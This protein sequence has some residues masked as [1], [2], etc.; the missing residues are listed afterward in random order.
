MEIRDHL[1]ML[2]A[3]SIAFLGWAYNMLILDRFR[4]SCRFRRIELFALFVASTGG[5]AAWI[6]ELALKSED[7]FALG[8]AAS[9]FRT[10]ANWI[11]L[12]IIVNE[13]V[14][15]SRQQLLS[16]TFKVVITVLWEIQHRLVITP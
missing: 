5:F 2:P 10:F 7:M 13:D 8:V 9:C 4:G 3:F 11:V 12:V 1:V 15:L 16:L 14:F 6:G